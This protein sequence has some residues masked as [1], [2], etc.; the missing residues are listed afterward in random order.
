MSA[1]DA[2]ASARAEGLVLQTARNATGFAGVK[3]DARGYAR[4][5]SCEV[6]SFQTAEEAAL[7]IARKR[8]SSSRS[9]ETDSLVPDL[10]L[11]AAPPTAGGC[12]EPEVPTEH[13]AVIHVNAVQVH[14][15][16]GEDGTV[17]TEPRACSCY[18]AIQHRIRV[19]EMKIAAAQRLNDAELTAILKQQLVDL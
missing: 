11:A 10:T 19:I 17:A 5:Y 12:L 7:A 14:D 1:A 16:D 8:G 9:D 6:G 13:D 4:P 15:S 3:H 2:L 18:T